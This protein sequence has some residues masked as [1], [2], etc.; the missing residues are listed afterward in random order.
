MATLTIR[1]D[2]KLDRELSRLAKR[3]KRTKSD[4][5]REMLR[6]NLALEAFEEARKRL[7]PLAEKAGYLTDEDIFRDFS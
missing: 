4:L 2:D 5:A 6:R 1:L 3:Q 7:V